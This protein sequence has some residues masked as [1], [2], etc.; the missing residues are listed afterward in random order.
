MLAQQFWFFLY[1][2][3][4]PSWSNAN[5]FDDI[6][7]WLFTAAPERLREEMIYAIKDKPV[8]AERLISHFSDTILSKIFYTDSI[9]V[10]LDGLVKIL[11]VIHNYIP[12]SPTKVREKYWL[13]VFKAS[14]AKNVLLDNFL[15]IFYEAIQPSLV[16]DKIS[17]TDD[18]SFFRILKHNIEEQLLDISSSW[19]ESLINALQVILSRLE[20]SSQ[21]GSNQTDPAGKPYNT[22]EPEGSAEHEHKSEDVIEN[23]T[24]AISEYKDVF[25]ETDNYVVTRSK[26]F[27]DKQKSGNKLSDDNA[28]YVDYAGIV[29]LH[30]FLNVLYTEMELLKE[31]KWVN[32]DAQQK[33]VQ[34]LA[35]LA[36]EEDFC[37]EYKMPLLKIL[38]GLRLEDVV[39]PDIALND[40]EKALID[41]LL[42]AVIKHWSAAGKMSIT[43]LRESFLQRKGKLV[44]VDKGWKLTV[45]RKTIDILIS[46]LPWGV[47]FVK[48]PWLNQMLFV[49]WV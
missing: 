3:Y 18:Y 29:L 1:N 7:G 19:K 12:L 48:L 13:S 22:I 11:T 42:L 44:P 14:Q 28:I 16:K 15:T 37:P 33:A 39:L 23:S 36:Q 5:F 45:E 9:K 47:S 2:G 10:P 21:K 25:I 41:E 24:S 34:A 35:C 6:T 31:R 46:K 4:L 17:R 49:D 40:R 8:I 32:T 26:R 20:E 43:G 27:S 30:P 38:C